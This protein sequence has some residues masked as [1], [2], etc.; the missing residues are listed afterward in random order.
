MGGYAIRNLKDV[1]NAAERFGLS[2]NLEFRSARE[3]LELAAF[4]L[5]YL[6]VAPGFRMPFGHRHARQE[7]AYVVLDGSGRIKLDDEV[8]DLKQWDAVR[9]DKETTRALEGGPDGI[10]ILAVGAP[11][12]GPGDAEMIQGWWSD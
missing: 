2:P 7:E 10:T 6:R 9:I 12:T 1:D 5:S 11:N 4:G 3:P 8:V